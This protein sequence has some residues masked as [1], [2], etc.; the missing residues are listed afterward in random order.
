M[1]GL[2]LDGLDITT[3]LCRLVLVLE[4]KGL[5]LDNLLLLARE[6]LW[7]HGVGDVQAVMSIND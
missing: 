6:L 5:V 1:H 7:W 3:D 2:V 4:S